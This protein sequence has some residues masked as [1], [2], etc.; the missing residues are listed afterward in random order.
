MK[1]QN[2]YSNSAAKR[3]DIYTKESR[4]IDRATSRFTILEKKSANEGARITASASSK[5]MSPN[6]IYE[7]MSMRTLDFSDPTYKLNDEHIDDLKSRYDLENISIEDFQKLMKELADDGIVSEGDKS[8]AGITEGKTRFVRRPII[9]GLFKR[10]IRDSLFGYT[11]FKFGSVFDWIEKLT[12][13]NDAAIDWLTN[14]KADLNDPLVRRKN[15]S[16]L[17]NYNHDATRI[18]EVLNQLK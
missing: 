18:F 14:S 13:Q 17:Q 2:H 11:D 3:L 15:I 4:N 12:A 16:S 7:Q 1:I 9:Q 10:E 8:I 6:E 5:A